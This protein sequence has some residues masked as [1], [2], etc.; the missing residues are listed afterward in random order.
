MEL[1]QAIAIGVAIVVVLAA[2]GWLL[3]Q[4]NRSQHLRERF[5]PEYDRRIAER[6]SR[7]MAESE[8]AESEHRARK[9][10]IQP[11][12]SSDRMRFIEEWRLC[13]ARFVD[14]PSGAVDDADHLVTTI[15]RTRGYATDDPDDRVADVSAAYP[16]QANTYRRAN[17]IVVRHHRGNASTEDLRR[18]FVDFRALFDEMLVGAEEQERRRAS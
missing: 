7:R 15:M 10:R 4:R 2:L 18:A 13:Q 8:L 12:S 16:N 5:G 9:L 11:L 3:Y 6:G 17:D 1:W 14:D